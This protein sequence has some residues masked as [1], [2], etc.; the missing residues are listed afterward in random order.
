M[1][2]VEGPEKKNLV[3]EELSIQHFLID[4]V[5]NY[6]NFEGYILKG[7]SGGP[8]IMRNRGVNYFLGVNSCGD[9]VDLDVSTGLDPLNLRKL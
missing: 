9:F 3:M 8:V 2:E 7:M 6:L 5:Q 1:H 4:E